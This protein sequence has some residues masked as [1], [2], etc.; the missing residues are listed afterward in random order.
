VKE[1]IRIPYPKTAAGKKEWNK[2]F[3]MNAYYS[4]KH[5]SKRKEDADFWHTLTRAA[6][7]KAQVRRRP[8]EK[9]VV[10]TFLWN[11]KLDLDN[12]SIMSKMIIDALKGRLINDDTRK[13]VR[14]IEHYWHEDDYIK[15]IL[16]E[17]E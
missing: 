14:G 4:G 6:M 3:G 17:I 11:D 12:H 8:F 5:W 9:P 7:S 10:I 1:I 2:R 13:W 15:V 16:Q